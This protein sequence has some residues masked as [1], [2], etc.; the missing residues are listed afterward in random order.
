MRAL[1]VP[2][3]LTDEERTTRSST[4]AAQ[5]AMAWAPSISRPGRRWLRSQRAQKSP[6]TAIALSRPTAARPMCLRRWA[7]R[8]RSRPSRR[9]ACLRATGFMFL[10]AT[11]ASSRTEACAAD[12]QGARLPHYLQPGGTT[13][14]PGGCSR[15]GHGSLRS[16]QSLSRSRD[17]G[18]AR[19]AARICCAWPDGLD[20]LTLTG[21][22]SVAEVTGSADRAT[23]NSV[24]LFRLTPEEAGLRCAS[25]RNWRELARP[26]KRRPA[27]AYLCGRALPSAMLS[28]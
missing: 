13:D 7:C 19:G 24:R 8:W 4:P 22:S 18:P 11:R 28:C 16:R 2:V 9:V 12:P 1:S 17:D 6:S 20:E 26:P 15:T 21:E 25:L 5:A 27:G 10:Y 23:G 14:K 3:P